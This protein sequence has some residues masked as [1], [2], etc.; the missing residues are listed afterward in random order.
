MKFRLLSENDVIFP[1]KN[2]TAFEFETDINANYKK[3]S[4]RMRLGKK[5]IWHPE[6]LYNRVGGQIG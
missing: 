1:L 5:R 3:T 6:N 4:K 2:K